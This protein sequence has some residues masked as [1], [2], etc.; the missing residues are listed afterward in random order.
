MLQGSGKRIHRFHDDVPDTRRAD[1]AD[2]VDYVVCIRDYSSTVQECNY[3]MGGRIKRIRR[4]YEVLAIDPALGTP[5]AFDRVLGASPDR[6]PD[7]KGPSR[8]GEKIKGDYP[9]FS[10]A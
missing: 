9:R 1:T 4:G 2:E 7:S 5:V 6:C 8:F 3:T 10:Y